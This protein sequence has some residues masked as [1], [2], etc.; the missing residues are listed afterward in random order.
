MIIKSFNV[1]DLKNTKCNFFLFYGE[2]DGH[3]DDIIYNF[4]IKDLG[5]EF[6]KYDENQI[7]DNRDSFFETCFNES[8]FGEKKII[9]VSRVTSKLYEIIKELK[10]KNIHDKKI[11]FNS[12]P[13]EK[14][15]KIRQLFEKEKDLIC[16]PFYQDNNISL[17][18]IASE[19]FKKKNISISNEN[20][21]LVVEKCAGDRKNLKNEIDKILNFCERRKKVSREE[22]IKL[23][24]LHGEENVFELIDFTLA[25]NHLRVIKII[26]SHSYGKSDSIILIR[27]FLSRIKRLIALKQL[28]KQTG[29]I[30]ETINFF[31]PAIFWKD[32]DIV[33]KQMELWS[34]EK[35]YSL[36]EKLN[37]LEI[38]FKKSSD[39]SNNLIFDLLLN[40]STDTNN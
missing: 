27:S 4:F 33:K 30:N 29:N 6:I 25:K 12:G 23:I 10:G 20:I 8:L 18:K 13:L 26:N 39:L 1:N 36:L 5:V 15:S 14:K 19:L 24:N 9:Q 16:I 11:I 28:D 40:T 31:K 35:I 37:K 17:N 3:K 22:I 2:N 34:I 38:K 7:L 21:N 32:K